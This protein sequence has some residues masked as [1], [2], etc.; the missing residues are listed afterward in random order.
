MYASWE[1][2]KYKHNYMV[3]SNENKFAF[4]LSQPAEHMS[5]INYN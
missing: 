1:A 3:L 5:P 4:L 2:T